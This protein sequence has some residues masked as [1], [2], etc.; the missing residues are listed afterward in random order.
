MAKFNRIVFGCRVIV[1]TALAIGGV[2][3]TNSIFV[4]SKDITE[5]GVGGFAI[6]M[7]KQRAMDVA[8]HEYVHSIRPILNVDTTYNYSNSETLSYLGENRS[9]EL[10]NG[11]D[12]KAIYT[13]ARCKV[14]NVRAFSGASAPFDVPV[15]ASSDDL[16]EELRK[17]LNKDHSLSAYEVVSSNNGAWFVLDQSSKKEMASVF[18]YD[19][20]SFEVT[21]TKPAGADFVVYFSEGLISRI[22]YKRPRIRVE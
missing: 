15:G 11:R 21:A 16:V 7:S 9:I 22:T 12:L 10:T 4:E 14:T 8:L 19:I 17:A 5:G 2:S 3:C 20:W 6:G 13:V 18:A 1:A